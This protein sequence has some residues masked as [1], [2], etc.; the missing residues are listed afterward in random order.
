MRIE[1][2]HGLTISLIVAI[3][4]M[5]GFP[6]MAA[7]GHAQETEAA[8]KARCGD[9]H[10]PRDIQDWGRQRADAAARQA[11]LGQF[12]SSTIR[13]PKPNAASSLPTFSQRSREKPHQNKRRREQLEADWM[14]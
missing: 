14:A 8:F 1:C 9:C 3:V 2:M 7:A 6:L 12:L 10:R 4:F 5:T 13:R 11:S